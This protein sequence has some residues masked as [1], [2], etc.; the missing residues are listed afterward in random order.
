MDKKNWICY[1]LI[2]TILSSG[3]YFLLRKSFSP[4][5]D[6]MVEDTFFS[7]EEWEDEDKDE[8]KEKRKTENAR[9]SVDTKSIESIDTKSI[10]TKSIETIEVY[11]CGAVKNPGVYALK[12]G[13]RVNDAIE[14]SGGLCDDADLEDWNLAAKIED[15]GKICILTKKEAKKRRKEMSQKESLTKESKETAEV[16]ETSESDGKVNINTASKAELMTLTGIGEAKAEAILSYREK[17][18]TY[19]SLEDLMKIEGIKSGVY[20][21][22]KDY[23]KL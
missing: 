13:D 11:I 17:N 8:K 10:D 1:I 23:I 6:G 20:N 7:E 3:A 5:K 9:E 12:T 4:K 21:K 16:L 2:F 19:G 14:R 22:I 18:G 15:G